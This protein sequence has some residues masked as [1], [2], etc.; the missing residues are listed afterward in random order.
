MLSNFWKLLTEF[1][2][3]SSYD[4][5]LGFGHVISVEKVLR[6]LVCRFSCLCRAKLWTDARNRKNFKE[7]RFLQNQQR[8]E[9]RVV[10]LPIY[11]KDEK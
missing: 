5:I 2:K 10:C 9:M 3:L 1:S 6:F 11:Y 4:N 8:W 7:R